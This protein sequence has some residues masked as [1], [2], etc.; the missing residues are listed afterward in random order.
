MSKVYLIDIDGTVCDDIKNEES[1]LYS[2]AKPYKN[3]REMLN[4]WYDEGNTIT[5]FTAREEKD[6]VVTEKWL[7]DN[8]FKYNGLI[9]GKPRIKEGQTYHWIDNR[10]VKATTYLGNWGELVKKK[11]DIEVFNVNDCGDAFDY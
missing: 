10:P 6:R 4:K 2:E 11:Y 7:K 5:F 3:S 1:H 8:N 9:M